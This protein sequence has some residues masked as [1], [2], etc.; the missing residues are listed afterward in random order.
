MRSRSLAL[1]IL[2]F[3]CIL[4]LIHAKTLL[5]CEDCQLNE[6]KKAFEQSQNG[7]SIIV[8]EGVYTCV[9]LNL[10]KSVTLIGEKGAVLDGKNQSYVL[11]IMADS[12]SVS[13]FKI[14]NSGKSY[15]KDFASIYIHKSDGF[16]ISNNLIQN[17][18]FAMLI[19]KSKNGII[20]DNRVLGTATREDQSGNGI[21]L[22]DCD[23]MYIAHNEV[24]GMRDGIYLEFVD[25]S[26]IIDNYS[27]HNVRYGLHFMFSNQ[28]EYKQNTFEKNG[29]GVAVM[30]SKWIR[31]CNNLFIN[32]WGS[33]SYGLLLKEIYD[34]EVK[35]NKFDR[36]TIAVYVDG[37]SRVSYTDNVFRQNGWAIKVSGGC[38][39]NHFNS[40]DF[41]GN[42]F[43]ISYHSML[44]DNTFNGNY[45]SDYSGY[46]LDKD[47][48]GDVPYR[49][50]K[51][52]SYITNKT[53]EAIVLMRSLFVDIINFSE[54]VSPVF[55]P[56]ALIDNAPSMNPFQ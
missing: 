53:P 38:Y 18:F 7:D 22:W 21:H 4:N 30:F 42:S 52:F 12:I 5:V 37:S 16:L 51:L 31:M 19:E 17:S 55:T 50:V 23:N 44:N 36:N 9:D 47:G 46:D 2:L 33:A 54:K 32:N 24:T 28:D 35:G 41:V 43:G 45:W 8:S 3:L 11:R 15:T 29:A 14:I 10:S 26:I 1:T 40:N 13:G 20:R 25:S 56:D 34:G 6:L 48:V 27:H 39:A 49:P